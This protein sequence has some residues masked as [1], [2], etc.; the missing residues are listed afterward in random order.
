MLL[1]K[2]GESST[3]GRIKATF[4][5]QEADSVLTDM[6]QNCNEA[7]CAQALLACSKHKAGTWSS[8]KRSVGDAV[9]LRACSV[10]SR[11]N[12]VCWKNASVPFWMCTR[13][14]FSTQNEMA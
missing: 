3:A 2:A 1:K 8:R 10:W 6:V 4:L 14:R 5:S 13:S 12:T 11:G 9:A 7:K